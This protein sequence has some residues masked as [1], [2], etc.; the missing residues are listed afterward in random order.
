MGVRTREKARTRKVRGKEATQD[1]KG[2][3]QACL[4]CP[5]LAEIR[6]CCMACY[7]MIRR[8]VVIGRYSDDEAVKTK[9]WLPRG[10]VGRRE[11]VQRREI[12]ARKKTAKKG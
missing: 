12:P 3:S 6:G 2:T 9:S 7:Q 1:A 5:R 4:H 11:S 8:D 10:K